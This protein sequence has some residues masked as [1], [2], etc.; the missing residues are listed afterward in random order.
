MRASC[1]HAINHS[2]RTDNPQTPAYLNWENAVCFCFCFVFL[3]HRVGYWR[4]V[5]VKQK[6]THRPVSGTAGTKRPYLQL[7]WCERRRIFSSSP[8]ADSMTACCG[9][10]WRC[11]E[12]SKK[13]PTCPFNKGKSWWRV[14]GTIGGSRVMRPEEELSQDFCNKKNHNFFKSREGKKLSAQMRIQSCARWSECR[15]EDIATLPLFYV[16]MACH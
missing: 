10:W 13:F 9:H 16:F 2:K 14:N 15:S 11:W 7:F 6:R 1:T 3:M 4:R 5:V 12:T 8:C